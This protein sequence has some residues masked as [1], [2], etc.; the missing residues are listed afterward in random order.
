MKCLGALVL[1]WTFVSF[2]CSFDSHSSISNWTFGAVDGIQLTFFWPSTI[3]VHLVDSISHDWGT[4]SH[5]GLTNTD[6]SST[7]NFAFYGDLF[8][9]LLLIRISLDFSSPP[10]FSGASAQQRKK[11][12]TWSSFP[13]IG[14]SPYTAPQLVAKHVQVYW[15]L[16]G[17]QAGRE[18]AVIW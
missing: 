12:K 3:P 14:S 8:N 5:D 18:K 10:N 4:G 13:L 16:H 15:D 9:V 6:V 17:C 2:A 11:V 7:D 1:S